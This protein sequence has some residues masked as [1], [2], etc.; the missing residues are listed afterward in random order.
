MFHRPHLLVI[1]NFDSFTFNLVDALSLL[2]AE[3]EV[4]RNTISAGEALALAQ[5]R[6]TR[7]IVLSPGPGAPAYAGC[8]IPLIREANG[9]FPLF[10]VCLGH[11]AMIEAYGGVV[12]GAG[13]IVHGK[14][15][16]IHHTG[17]PLFAGFPEEFDAGRYHSLAARVMPADLEVI[18]NHSDVVMAVAHRSQPAWGVQFHPESVL[19]THGQRLLENV[20]GLAQAQ[21][22]AGPAR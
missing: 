14:K 6:G 7:L 17:H 12:A 19:T 18:A 4:Y 20:W 9:K 8:C 10:G 5:K 16:R 15:S 2:G 1:D 21:H 13:E 3:V 22:P 11:Q